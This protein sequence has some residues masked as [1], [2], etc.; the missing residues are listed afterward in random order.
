MT[1]QYHDSGCTEYGTPE[2]VIEAARRTMGTIDLDPASTEFFNRVV[3]ATRYFTLADDGLAQP[4]F[5]HVWLNHPFS[6]EGNRRWIAKL[7]GEYWSGNVLGAC[8][9]TY[10]STSEGWF[11]P[12]L[13]HP[14][15]FLRGRTNYYD[16]GGNTLRGVMKGSVVT[17]FG[18]YGG[19]FR[20]A[21]ASLGTVK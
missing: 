2:Y 8:A 5:G 14:Q 21:F 13:S 18:P 7:L 9:I 12:L 19:Q 4:W 16:A 20:V 17:Y 3:R 11:Q 6:R 1:Y 15:C 10:A